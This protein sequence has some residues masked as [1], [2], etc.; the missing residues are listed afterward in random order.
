MK[1]LLLTTAI[2]LTIAMPAYASGTH[3]GGHGAAKAEAHGADGH[4]DNHADM[5]MIGMPGD[6]SKV[7]RT[8]NITMVE[9]DDGKMLLEGDEMTFEKGETIRFVI[10]NKG[11][12]E[13][14]FVLDTVERNADHKIE[15]AKM[16]ME[17]DDPNR[18]TL[19]AGASGEVIWTF[20]NDGA[21]EA[22]CLMPG[23]YES[24]MYRAVAVG[25]H[26]M[27]ADMKMAVA[28]VQVA[29]ADVE[30]T[31][32]KVTKVDAKGGKVTIDHGP[33]LNLDMP[34]MKMVFRADEAMIS[35]LS[36]GQEIE[37]VAEPVKGKLTVTQLK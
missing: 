14:E 27:K 13:H 26:A 37:F 32:G 7:D 36:E 8:I 9:T 22:A 23:H 35:K 19:D 3:D 15:M 34:A 10:E 28:E 17:H 25:E 20:S 18:I 5:M 29:Q 4:S 2:A 30:Y 31:K 1:N 21:F 33:L 24:G 6:A 16:M 12:Q 11:E